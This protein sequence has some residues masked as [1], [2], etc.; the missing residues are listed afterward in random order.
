[1]GEVSSYN[2]APV[3]RLSGDA[4]SIVSGAVKQLTDRS[5]K[6]K[7][8]ALQMLQTLVAVVPDCTSSQLGSLLPCLAAILEVAPPV[9]PDPPVQCVK[10]STSLSFFGCASM[11]SYHL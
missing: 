8:G 11:V 9:R 10:T 6:A 4:A 2:K 1:V 3:Q 7:A 5:G